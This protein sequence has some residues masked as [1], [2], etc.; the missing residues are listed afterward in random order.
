MFKLYAFSSG[1]TN[2]YGGGGVAVDNFSQDLYFYE[3]LKYQVIFGSGL[4]VS[5]R[6]AFGGEVSFD[7]RFLSRYTPYT[8]KVVTMLTGAND[9]KS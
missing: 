2:V 4:V 9:I 7:A 8:R 6:L 5:N 1:D 3:R